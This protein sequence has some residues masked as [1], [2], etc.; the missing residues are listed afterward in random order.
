MIEPANTLL[1]SFIFKH[2]HHEPFNPNQLGW[3]LPSGGR[4]SIANGALPWIVFCRD[5]S[6]FEAEF[7]TLF[8]KQCEAYMPFRYI[9]SGG[10]SIRQLLPAFMYKPM[11]VLENFLSPLNPL[12]G[13][14][15]KITLQKKDA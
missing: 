15:L 12:M 6:K 9:V 2:F 5:Q 14:F 7:P 11:L 10:L 13:M 8:L 4:L 1:S 3:S